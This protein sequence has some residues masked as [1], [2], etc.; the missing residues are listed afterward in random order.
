M[1]N[2]KHKNDDLEAK[3]AVYAKEVDALFG[4]LQEKIRQQKIAEEEERVR[5]IKEEMEREKMKKEEEIQKKKEEEEL[6]K[7]FL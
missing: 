4:N 6:K 2:G 1:Q 3:Y 5:K 7:R